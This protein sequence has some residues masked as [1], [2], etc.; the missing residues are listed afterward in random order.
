MDKARTGEHLKLGI[1]Q[2]FKGKQYRVLGKAENTETGD[3]MVIYKALY[4]EFKTY[5]RPY[6]MFMSKVDKEKY[7]NADQEYRFKWIFE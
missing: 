4:G 7:P 2:H 1:Y 6:N 5:V 3:T